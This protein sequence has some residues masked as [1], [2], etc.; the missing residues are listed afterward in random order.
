[1]GVMKHI[2]VKSSRN[3]MALH[4]YQMLREQLK[5]LFV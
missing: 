1:M 4:K 3:F 2:K 5:T